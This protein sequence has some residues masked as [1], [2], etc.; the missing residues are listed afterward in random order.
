[1]TRRSFSEDG[2]WTLWRSRRTSLAPHWNME[3]GYQW[4]LCVARDGRRSLGIS[5]TGLLSCCWYVTIQQCS[6]P[7]RDIRHLTPQLIFI[8]LS[9]LDRGIQS[10]MELLPLKR[11]GSV[12]H[13]SNCCLPPPFAGYASC[14]HTC[15]VCPLCES[16]RIGQAMWY[17]ISDEEWSCHSIN[18]SLNQSHIHS[19]VTEI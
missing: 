13:S 12:A 6:M 17:V 18:C 5:Y 15:F 16:G 4:I 1:M 3:H 9:R 11:G 8:V 2:L 10:A 7:K 14:W 19:T